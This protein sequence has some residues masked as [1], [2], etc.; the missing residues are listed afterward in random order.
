[1]SSAKFH[2]SQVIFP[3]GIAAYCI[4]SG[5]DVRKEG[6]YVNSLV[7]KLIVSYGHAYKLDKLNR[8]GIFY[9]FS[10]RTFL[11]ADITGMLGSKIYS[12]YFIFF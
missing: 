9:L 11:F 2:M 8:A 10:K 3:S 1:M 6:L 4:S 7:V 12:Y 5:L